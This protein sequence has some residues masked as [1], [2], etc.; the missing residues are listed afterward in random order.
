VRSAAELTK[1]EPAE[2]PRQNAE[3]P[4]VRF[5]LQVLA[6]LFLLT[7]AFG[8]TF[9]KLE[10]GFSWLHPTEVVLV[11]VVA[12]ALLRAPPRESVRRIRQTGALVPLL[13]LWLFGAVAVMRGLMDWGFS[14]VLNDIGLIEYSVFVPLLVL[15]VRDRFELLWLCRVIALAGLLAIAALA[16]SFWAPSP[17]EVSSTLDLIAAA[18]GMYAILYVA[19]IA[20]RTAAG[21]A[22][23]PWHYAAVVFAVGL[24]ILGSARSA[25]VGLIVALATVGAFALPGHRVAFAGRVAAMLVL[26]AA[27][28]AAAERMLVPDVPDLAAA[29]SHLVAS[30]EPEE[31]SRAPEVAS[32]EPE[33]ASTEPEEASRA[34]EVASREPEEASREPEGASTEPEEASRA[35]EGASREPEEA[36]R[37]R[38]HD[39]TLGG[40]AQNAGPGSDDAAARTNGGVGMVPEPEP[41]RAR[42]DVAAAPRTHRDPAAGDSSITVKARPYSLWQNSGFELGNA[43]G[44]TSFGAN[45]LAASADRALAG[46]YSLEAVYG[47]DL[48]LAATLT[49]PFGAATRHLASAW[50][51]V[52]RAWDGGAITLGTDGTWVGAAET[53]ADNSTTARGEW[54]RIHIELRPAVTD[55][56]G[57]VHIRAASAPSAGRQVYIDNL[58]IRP[59]AD[60]SERPSARPDDGAAAQQGDEASGLAELTASFQDTPQQANARW[61]LSFW[62]FLLEE[63]ARRPFIG[64]GFGRPSNF[65]WNGIHYDRRT[66]DPQDP[67]DVIAPHNSFLNLLYRT[68]LPGFLA[69]A[70]IMLLAVIRL[71]PVA[72]RTRGEDKALAIWLLAAI[73]A[74]TVAASFNVALEGPFMGIFFWAVLGLALLAPQF[75]GGPP[76]GSNGR[77]ALAP[78]T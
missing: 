35:P 11:V 24:V 61:R 7:G 44:Y 46:T 69:L 1:L 23:Q 59:A 15:L 30:T 64:V 27:L 71:V 42:P 25:W 29:A 57:G 67:F 9:S 33:G 74:T 65:E 18:S 63:S 43:N 73:A 47:N 58:T 40:N 5:E 48:R 21:V 22:V 12:A 41:A 8:R 13:I 76:E 60:S 28:S 75:L 39:G 54:A 78:R 56:L 52:P 45:T 32:R 66:G 19:W 51:Y 2:T 50:V 6:A 17:W 16:A 26:G 31:A 77:S 62:K 53:A 37:V 55:L 36:S 10:L 68:G 4:R 49:F 14:R 3:R 34:P 70:A 72:R 38:G 20:A